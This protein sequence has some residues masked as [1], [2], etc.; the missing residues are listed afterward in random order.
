LPGKGK[1]PPFTGIPRPGAGGLV[2]PLAARNK[3]AAAAPKVLSAAARAAGNLPF[4]RAARARIELSPF[5]ARGI[6]PIPEQI[7]GIRMGRP[8]NLREL[9]PR[10]EEEAAPPEAQKSPEKSL[11][12]TVPGLKPGTR[13]LFPP[14]SSKPPGAGSPLV[15]PPR[16]TVPKMPSKPP[17]AVDSTS[18]TVEMVLP[19]DVKSMTRPK[20]LRPTGNGA[21][22]GTAPRQPPAAGSGTPRPDPRK[23]P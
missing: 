17:A 23:R 9:L 10:E 15:A 22:G 12:F 2:D 4:S 3:A 7:T 6:V 19:D 5:A 14:T 18:K 11:G 13:P 8:T 1:P 20:G 16:G 21:A